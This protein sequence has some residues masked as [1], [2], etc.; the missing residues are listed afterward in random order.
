MSA[1]N[2]CPSRERLL[3]IISKTSFALDDLRLFLDTHPDD[4]QALALFKKIWQNREDAKCQ[5]NE[6][7]GQ[8]NSYDQITGNKWSWNQKLPWK[9]DC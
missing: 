6:K 7:Y 1:G 9:G 5:Y 2:N 8:I 4:E 3:D